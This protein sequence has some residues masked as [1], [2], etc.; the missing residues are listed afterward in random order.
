MGWSGVELGVLHP[1]YSA[2]LHNPSFPS[3]GDFPGKAAELEEN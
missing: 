3:G 2:F 1:A